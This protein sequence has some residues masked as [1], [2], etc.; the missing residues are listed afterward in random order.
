MSLEP[1]HSDVF[2]F[3][4]VTPGKFLP[5]GGLRVMEDTVHQTETTLQLEEAWREEGG[6]RI[7]DPIVKPKSVSW[8]KPCC[9][10]GCP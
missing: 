8:E 5:H 1:R 9:G 6:R 3:L 2:L 4:S 7:F 10:V